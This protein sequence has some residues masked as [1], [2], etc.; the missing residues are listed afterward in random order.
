MSGC[1]GIWY[2]HPRSSQTNGPEEVPGVAL[3]ICA[4]PARLRP[5]KGGPASVVV[6]EIVSIKPNTDL[7]GMTTSSRFTT[8]TLT[9]T[10]SS[11]STGRLSILPQIKESDSPVW[12]ATGPRKGVFEKAVSSSPVPISI[13]IFEGDS[14]LTGDDDHVDINPLSGKRRL[15]FAFDLCALTLT[16]DINEQ[17]QGLHHVTGGSGDEAATIAFRVRLKDGRPVSQTD[18]ALVDLD[19]IQVVPRTSRLVA[20]K[21]TVVLVLIANNHPVT[22]NTTIRVRITGGSF[23][24]EETFPMQIKAGE[25]QKRYLFADHPIHFPGPRLL[26]PSLSSPRSSIPA[27]RGCRRAIVAFGN[28]ASRSG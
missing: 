13:D 15:D 6:V 24:V 18:L 8:I 11:R 7:E 22:I 1:S 23:V 14:G 10:A 12:E 4:M 28:D 2:R 20:R 21:G 9:S 17:S 19:L 16:G 5:W 26:T 27:R 3:R 25:V